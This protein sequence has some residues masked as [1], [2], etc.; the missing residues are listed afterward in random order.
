MVWQGKHSDTFGEEG[1]VYVGD[2]SDDEKNNVV[3]ES[4]NDEEKRIYQIIS[5]D[6]RKCV[7]IES[8]NDEE[9]TIYQTISFDIRNTRYRLEKNWFISTKTNF[10]PWTVIC[11]CVKG[12]IQ[13]WV[14]NLITNKN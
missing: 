8:G 3:I 9:E 4:S 5:F 7:V 13:N 11:C 6:I 1:H 10:H 14:E 2:Y 12:N